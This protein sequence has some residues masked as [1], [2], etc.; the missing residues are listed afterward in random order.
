[1]SK[2]HLI[3]T[4]VFE[5]P[6]DIEQGDVIALAGYKLL[7]DSLHFIPPGGRVVEDAVHGQQG[8]NGQNLLRTVEFGGQEDGLQVKIKN[9]VNPNSSWL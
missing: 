1:M 7:P 4:Q 6:V 3:S 8:D 5:G 9:R 2:A